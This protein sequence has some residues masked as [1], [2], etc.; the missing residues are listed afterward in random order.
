VF[1]RC[2]YNLYLHY[3]QVFLIHHCFIQTFI[4]QGKF[5]CHFLKKIGFHR[6]PLSRYFYFTSF[7]NKVNKR[8][9]TVE[10]NL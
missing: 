6:L 10:R 1:C 4:Q 9:W 2:F 5:H 7:E 3:L 8:Y